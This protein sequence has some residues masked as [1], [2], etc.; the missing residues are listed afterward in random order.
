VY[1]GS[2]ETPPQ[3]RGASSTC[4]SIVIWTK[5]SLAAAQEQGASAP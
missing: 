4:G 5:Q 3:F 2:L 1:P